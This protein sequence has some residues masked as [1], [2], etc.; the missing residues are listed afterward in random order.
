MQI[1]PIAPLWV[2]ELKANERRK[3]R[4]NRTDLRLHAD[5]CA[6]APKDICPRLALATLTFQ[7]D[8]HL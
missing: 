2:P 1:A 7:S 6:V 8:S 3:L 4:F 5:A